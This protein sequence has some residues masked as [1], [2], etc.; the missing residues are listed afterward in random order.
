MG[1]L[2]KFQIVSCSDASN[3]GL[4]ADDVACRLSKYQPEGG[5]RF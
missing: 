4:F 2:E 5:C 1:N 3:T